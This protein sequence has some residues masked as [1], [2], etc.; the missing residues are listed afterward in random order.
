MKGKIKTTLLIAVLLISTIAGL[1][2]PT[3]LAATSMPAE[4]VLMTDG[5][6]TAYWSAENDPIGLY[7]VELDYAGDGTWCGVEITPPSGITVADLADIVEGWSFWY[8]VA[9]GS[10]YGPLLELRFVAPDNVDPDGAGHLDITVSSVEFPADYGAQDTW[11]EL[12]IDSTSP[13]CIYYG[14]DPTDGTEFTYN[15]EGENPLGDIMA[16]VNAETEMT[17]GSDTCDDW[18]LVR[19][20]AQLGWTGAASTVYIDDITID[21]VDYELEPQSLTVGEAYDIS[22]TTDAIATVE[23]DYFPEDDTELIADIDLTE[24]SNAEGVVNFYNVIP[25]SAMNWKLSDLTGPAD[26]PFDAPNTPEGTVDINYLVKMSCADANSAVYFVVQPVED[27][28][29]VVSPSTLDVDSGTVPLSVTVTSDGAP[30]GDSYVSVEFWDEEAEE[31]YTLDTALL[32]TYET[33]TASNGMAMFDIKVPEV[34]GTIYVTA[35]TDSGPEAKDDFDGAYFENWGHKTI[36]VAPEEFLDI[37]VSPV[38]YLKAIPLD[39]T[40]KLWNKDATKDILK[41]SVTPD[42]LDIT[43]EGNDMNGEITSTV[44][45]IIDSIWFYEASAKTWTQHMGTPYVFTDAEILRIVGH[46]DGGP[47]PITEA[48]IVTITGFKAA[49]VGDITVT[50][51]SD[52][53]GVHGGNTIDTIEL[54]LDPDGGADYIE[55]APETI[56]VSEPAD[57]NIVK[58]GTT[59]DPLEVLF[60]A[61]PNNVFQ[62]ISTTTTIELKIHDDIDGE[63]EDDVLDEDDFKVTGVKFAKDPEISYVATRWV[64]TI[65]P[66]ESGTITVEVTYE[67]ETATDI[68]SEDYKI[69]GLMAS[70]SPD[71]FTNTT[72]YYDVN[73][74][75][76]TFEGLPVS[77]APVQLQQANTVLTQH[78]E[79]DDEPAYLEGVRPGDSAGVYRFFN[80]TAEQ[81]GTEWD[82]AIQV[83]AGIDLG[84]AIGDYTLEDK[85]YGGESITVSY[86]VLDVSLDRGNVTAL[87]D[88]DVEITVLEGTTPIVGATIYVDGCGYVDSVGGTTDS[89]GEATF[90][91]DGQKGVIGTITLRAETSDKTKTGSTT[92]NVSRPDFMLYNLTVNDH[93]TDVVTAGLDAYIYNA[94]VVDGDGS[95]ILSTDNTIVTNAEVGLY[96]NASSDQTGLV[97]GGAGVDSGKLLLAPEG[98]AIT[99]IP[100]VSTTKGVDA[101][102][103]FEF[104]VCDKNSDGVPHDEANLLNVYNLT[105][106]LPIVS[107]ST[108]PGFPITYTAYVGQSQNFYVKIQDADGVPVEGATIEIIAAGSAAASGETDSD[109]ETTITWEPTSTGTYKLRLNG[110]LNIGTV[111]VESYT[112]PQLVIDYTPKPVYL[113]NLVTIS[114]TAD[115]ELSPGI[116]VSIVDPDGITIERTTTGAGTCT[117]TA[118]KLEAWGIWA[119]YS[120]DDYEYIS[121]DVLEYEQPELPAETTNE[122]TLDSTGAPKTSFASGETVLV[123]ADVSNVGTE[124]QS[125]LIVVQLKDPDYR[126]LAPSYISVTLE[127]GQSLTPSIGFVLPMTGY[128]T[129]TW[130][131]K[132][133]VFDDWPALGGVTIGEPVTITFTVTS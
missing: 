13:R 46:S 102:E 117:F 51:C 133:M 120:E 114:V 16:L 115:G 83:V 43:L 53:G 81:V 27:Y 95:I 110:V 72:A 60:E 62:A 18:E 15:E 68:A 105:I 84:V 40:I 5:V 129:G 22:W 6:S 54:P 101:Y 41:A 23:L 77:T 71:Q 32:R 21:D 50:A 67:T 100:K 10:D 130:T 78:L 31:F 93:T 98:Y 39:L 108:G 116:S 35:G 8:Y 96:F 132:V 63:L 4:Y 74:T 88:K 82:N 58:V 90:E 24:I 80:V 55:T 70:V 113:D 89:K 42:A 25:S 103:L 124:S 44:T 49:K 91:Y 52:I 3:V 19:I 128:T 131:A 26:G 126:V 28:D 127:P 11:H 38:S 112:P 59:P 1:A 9:T 94:T 104:K 107:S 122:E 14:N 12:Q 73:V 7:S 61:L 123:S 92:L 2:M 119:Y 64:I 76:T 97:T 34:A 79:A 37:T 125:M 69:Y 111:T 30:V 29:V 106:S 85:N 57:L 86:D 75:L 121:I 33:Q 99:K 17:D 36:P 56:T 20:Q 87:I 47:Y 66:L 48:A 109:G 65:Y 45:Y 118:D